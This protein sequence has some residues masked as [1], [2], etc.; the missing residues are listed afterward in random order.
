MAEDFSKT[1]YK[2]EVQGIAEAQRQLA[3]FAKD[4]AK[5]NEDLKT[6]KSLLATATTSGSPQRITELTTK[7]KDLGTEI[8]NLRA[9]EA[10]T[11]KEMDL[12]LDSLQEKIN[13]EKA[14][15]TATQG[16]AQASKQAA[17]ANKEEEETYKTLRQQ[18]AEL[19]IEREKLREL[20]RETGETGLLGKDEQTL[21]QMDA[22]YK[23]LTAR[24]NENLAIQKETKGIVSELNVVEE[25]SVRN[26]QLRRNELQN[27]LEIIKK[28]SS[29]VFEKEI[30][31]YDE[32][33]KKAQDLNQEIA[34][35]KSRLNEIDGVVEKQLSA[36]DK[37]NQD[38][39][40]LT[41]A[42]SS[43]EL[44]NLSK[45]SFRGAD[46]G[47]TYAQD[48]LKQ[49]IADRERVKE[50]IESTTGSITKQNE[51]EQNSV[52]K[53]R[54][55]RLE[56]EQILKNRRVGATDVSIGGVR[57]D[58]QDAITQRNKLKAAEDELTERIKLRQLAM[59]ASGSSVDALTAKAKLLE[60][61]LR[62]LGDS[63]TF[64]Q[65]TEMQN[66][67]ATLIP[68]FQ[69]FTFQEVRAGEANDL[70]AQ[71]TAKANSQLLEFK[72]T[73]A[74]TTPVISES[75]EAITQYTKGMVSILRQS[76]LTDVLAGA[77]TEIQNSIIAQS[78]KL[79]ELKIQYESL[80][81][82]GG[83][84]FEAV[85]KEINETIKVQSN[86]I[87][88]SKVLN[89]TVK[90]T[91]NIGS[92]MTASI[93]KGFTNIGRQITQT[94]GLY[95]G[96]QA[97]ISG[98]MRTITVDKE[99]TD[100]FADLQR[101]LETTKEGVNGVV[102]SLRKIDTRT[103]IT[104]LADM[105]VMAG[106]AGVAV[107]DIAGVTEAINK[108][109]LVVGKDFGGDIEKATETLVKLVNIFIGPGQA[110]ADNV[111]HIANALITLDQA[112]VATADF[113]ARFSEE[114]SGIQGITKIGLPS[115]L[116]L[117]AAFQE[118][119]IR[120][121][122][123]STAISQILIR[124]GSD[125]QKYA[126]LANNVKVTNITDEQVDAFR[127]LL[128]DNPGEALIELAQGLKR[129]KTNF[130]EF[131]AAFADLGAKGFKVTSVFGDMA[132]KADFFRQKIELSKEALTGQ[133]VVLDGAALK[134]DTMAGVLDKIAAKFQLAFSNPELINT[135]KGFGEL[136]LNFTTALTS[137][138]F[139][140]IEAALVSLSAAWILFKI[141]IDGASLASRIFST[142]LG[143][144]K[145]VNEAVKLGVLERAE[146]EE[147]A[148]V[149][150][151]KAANTTGNMRKAIEAQVVSEA[152]S[153]KSKK[154][155]T[156]ATELRNVAGV[157]AEEV[158]IAEGAATRSTTIATTALAE[159][160]NLATVAT[161]GMNVALDSSPVGIILASIGL[162]IPLFTTLGDTT[163]DVTKSTDDLNKKMD[164]QA[165]TQK[166][167]A[168]NIATTV[169][170]TQS[171]LKLYIGI[172]EDEHMSL[173]TR[174]AAY[175]ELIKL[176]PEF[177]G[178][179]NAE[180]TS[181][182]DLKL[183]V[184]Q[185]NKANQDL[186]ISL[187]QL[188][189]A[190]AFQQLR[191]GAAKNL[192]QAKLDL[193]E[194]QTKIRQIQQE[195]KEFKTDDIQK[196]YDKLS[197]DEKKFYE[198]KATAAAR[199]EFATGGVTG[200]A[201]FA[202]AEKDRRKQLVEDLNALKEDSKKVED[203]VT[204]QQGISDEVDKK[205][206]DQY[207][208]LNKG[209]QADQ[210][211]KAKV[212]DQIDKLQTG[213]SQQRNERLKNLL[214]YQNLVTKTNHDIEL[215]TANNNTSEL[216]S[217]KKNLKTYQDKVAEYSAIN[218]KEKEINDLT[219]KQG[220]LKTN[221]TNAQQ[222]IL[223]TAGIEVTTD[224][225]V[226][227]THVKDVKSKDEVIA[228][229]E[230]Q[231]DGLN[232]QIVQTIKEQDSI[233]QNDQH[234]RE[235]QKR[236]ENLIKERRAVNQ[237][238][239]E[240]GVET[241]RGGKEGLSKQESSILKYFEAQKQLE[242]AERESEFA[243]LKEDHKVT[244]DEET[245]YNQ[246]ILGITTKW[247]K[248]KI[249]AIV[250][251]NNAEKLERAKLVKE[252]ADL[253]LVTQQ[254]ILNARQQVLNE[255]AR[256]T[257][258]ALDARKHEIEEQLNVIANIVDVSA[259]RVATAQRDM[260]AELLQQT[261]DKYDDLI[262]EAKIFGLST[263][264]LEEERAK[265]LADI[266]KDMLDAERKMYDAYF[267][268]IDKKYAKQLEKAQEQ[269]NN[270]RTSILN[271]G[272]GAKAQQNQLD[273][274][275][276]YEKIFES[277]NKLQ[278]LQE[279]FTQQQLES[280]L[281][282]G[283]SEVTAGKYTESIVDLTGK[284]KPNIGVFLATRE[285]AEKTRTSILDVRTEIKKALD[286]MNKAL[287]DFGSTKGLAVAG[288]G[289]IFKN[290]FKVTDQDIADVKA[291]GDKWGDAHKKVAEK[292]RNQELLG[293]VVAQS[294]AIAQQAMQTYFENEQ[295]NIEKSKQAA[296]DRIDVEKQQR[297]AQAQSKAEQ[298]TIEREAT[299]DKAKAD[300]AA[301]E[302]LKKVKLS[303]A[304][305]SF[306]TEL[307]NIAA[308]AAANPLNG[309][310][311]GTAGIIMYSLLAGL[312]YGR[313][314]LNVSAINSAKFEKG[315]HVDSETTRGGKVGG[316]SHAEG[317]NP[318]LFHG[319]VFQDEVGEL[320]V[321]RTR[322]TPR[323]GRYNISGSQEQIASA[324]NEI[325]G[326][327]KFS[328]GAFVHKFDYGGTLNS[329]RS[330]SSAFTLSAPSPEYF[331]TRGGGGGSGMQELANSIIAISKK[332]DQTTE[333]MNTLA[334]QTNTRIDKLKVHVVA[335]EVSDT[336][337]NIKK[338]SSIGRL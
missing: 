170:S 292:Q 159:S 325:G 255:D 189:T 306:A 191:E 206:K 332:V 37:L 211:E 110:T 169:D 111:T 299:A 264:V 115:V 181:V 13:A 239:K 274:A 91:G 73:I 94:I 62:S 87:S 4:I 284:M 324:L 95:F 218:G 199:S 198:N 322:N 76:G 263:E 14:A 311:F 308:S 101:V 151:V 55:E 85:K 130:D 338:A 8:D 16:S 223:K 298:D 320:N 142:D 323:G 5:F 179:I 66:N 240:L 187:N 49:M 175:R 71:E 303:E 294:Y 318:F 312:A 18:I 209:M 148:R 138:P 27:I 86:L 41:N 254:R 246:D 120:A 172:L 68:E 164:V 261:A 78:A 31:S 282:F 35:E 77:R 289:A 174:K 102:D 220:Q 118:T 56:L 58:I 204:T 200:I 269:F 90:Q 227:D 296:Y 273:A 285:E 265:R 45:F 266:N 256:V 109:K 185:L 321:I 96:I 233:D 15:T 48:V 252:V 93:S 186:L 108:L 262:A 82:V 257:R 60:L 276:G 315:G 245:Q 221:I 291:E 192:G 280:D 153:T 248:R 160:E 65:F 116:G 162:L 317:G 131:G 197:E 268:D 79:A 26:L 32:L 304:K 305:I 177:V 9:K 7:I 126:A 29:G 286:E 147:I 302:Q 125:I 201:Q 288:V 34:I 136:L 1:I 293:D 300:K 309:V 139:A 205:I 69:Q 128:R 330:G 121:E 163:D 75:T 182:G 46:I 188:A 195:L 213:A 313:Y 38:I 166:L 123:S 84:A 236:L 316:R 243:R 329:L 234:V 135:I 150:E 165:E 149:V 42:L 161:E 137:I 113:I 173:E 24:L 112:G 228:S 3:Q 203:A 134:E 337:K 230:D 270:L 88:Q 335:R 180:A 190:T 196:R 141:R 70:L 17:D 11:R 212:D 336:D 171:K 12:L 92:S 107:K 43:A 23:E 10:A 333:N 140:G 225:Q 98:I 231:L 51:A 307:A 229:L 143:A 207:E 271:S 331:N 50:V 103:P 57:T 44:Q 2:I 237:K 158:L 168:Q 25:G 314:A 327:I 64:Q 145:I 247:D 194:N 167:T 281:A 146:A 238:L 104:E 52:T 249:E 40:E 183:N 267:Q 251:N 155:N 244:L 99:L 226:V 328:P 28:G 36:W 242:L 277:M 80:K 97:A 215:A 117:G 326:G 106:K 105:A 334:W 20:E 319:R 6:T 272:L 83:E 22:Q 283:Q 127:K 114:M 275:S 214:H 216:A 202:S 47:T 208:A 144:M 33:V 258:K 53:L 235:L 222:N 122:V 63:L 67:L 72:K 232:Q 124:I 290:S 30:L 279:K 21:A 241:A 39:R 133:N 297:L 295:A 156:E 217:L 54:E 61:S 278:N 89:E 81:A 310:T 152:L 193:I 74:G 210:A 19:N 119:G 260:D 184:D 129:N 157:Q 253:D 224:D 259:E 132:D 301:G 287:L 219:E 59:D 250:G 154:L 100:K 176:S 178:A